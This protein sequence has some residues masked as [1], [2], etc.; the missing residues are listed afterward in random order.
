[1]LGVTGLFFFLG[2]EVLMTCTERVMVETY[3]WI[4][5]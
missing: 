3:G 4:V 5:M 2:E 1:M